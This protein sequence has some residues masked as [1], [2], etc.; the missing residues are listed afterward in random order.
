MVNFLDFEQTIK[1][2]KEFGLLT[3][4]EET[5]ASK[6]FLLVES[7]ITPKTTYFE[8]IE[9][10]NNTKGVKYP[11]DVKSRE[12]FYEFSH[13]YTVNDR[14]TALKNALTA[15]YFEDKKGML[16]PS[17][18]CKPDFITSYVKFKPTKNKT[19]ASANSE[20]TENQNI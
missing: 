12:L 5:E 18:V 16:T 4:Q 8:F 11:P 6:H 15:E 3:E 17:F 1:R 14:I 9:N 10:F 13:I 20:Y 7:L 2:I 19:N